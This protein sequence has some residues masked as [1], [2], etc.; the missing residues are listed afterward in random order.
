MRSAM[1][2]NAEGLNPFRELVLSL[3]NKKASDK[4]TFFQTLNKAQ[5][6][7]KQALEPRVEFDKDLS[8]TGYM[9]YVV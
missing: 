1:F 8:A 4:R 6:L 9:V 5:T 2:T 7:A 3:E